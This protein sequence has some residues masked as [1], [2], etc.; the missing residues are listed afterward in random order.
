MS[1]SICPIYNEAQYFDN[2]GNPLSG[3]KIFQY[4]AGSFTVQQTTYSD[5]DGLVPN[6]NPIVLDSSGRQPTELYLTNGSAYNLVLTLADG[7]TILDFKD[8]VVGVEPA[9]AVQVGINVWNT[10]AETP[11]YVNPNTFLVA[12]TNYTN[13]FFVG[14]R[15]RITYTDTTVSYGTV[16]GVNFAA[17]NTTVVLNVDSGNLL[18]NMEFVA[19]SSL[20][21]NGITVDSA[22]VSYKNNISYAAGSVGNKI[23]TMETALSTSIAEANT[24]IT[25]NA[26][27]IA[28]DYVTPY[29]YI[30]TF[31]TAPL[32]VGDPQVFTVIFIQGNGGNASTLNVNGLGALPLQEYNSAG[33]L[34]PARITAFMTSQVVYSGTAYL[35]LDRLPDP[36]AVAPRGIAVYTSNNTF[37]VPAGVFYIKVTCVGGGALGGQ[38]TSDTSSFPPQST[39]GA[40]GGGGATSVKYLSVTPGQ[41]YA[42]AIG[43]GGNIGSLGAGGTTSFGINLAAANGAPNTGAGATIGIGDIIFAGGNGAFNPATG[44]LGGSTQGGGQAPQGYGCGGSGGFGLLAGDDGRSGVCYVEW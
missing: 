18:S 15:V 21:A 40:G 29:D 17:G 19:W 20:I 16:T 5:I 37:T 2:N 36:T 23:N 25:R 8:N 44:S 1:V 28:A 27:W 39:F 7:T 34:V 32:N 6:P 41:T 22:G 26:Q 12:G 43:A 14:N 9:A 24:R 30:V 11:T 10:L 31:P 4:E 13:E 33:S 3:G 38:G 35:V 42:V